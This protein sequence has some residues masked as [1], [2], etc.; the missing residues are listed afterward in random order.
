MTRELQGYK[1]WPVA[2]NVTELE[3]RFVWE[4]D[5]CPFAPGTLVYL[6]CVQLPQVAVAIGTDKAKAALG[7][8]L[9]Q[10]PFPH[11]GDWPLKVGCALYVKPAW[12][13]AAPELVPVSEPEPVDGVLSGVDLRRLNP[14]RV[15]VWLKSLAT[16]PEPFSAQPWVQD[17]RGLWARRP[18]L[19]APPPSITADSFGVDTRDAAAMVIQIVFDIP[20]TPTGNV[21]RSYGRFTAATAGP[22]SKQVVRFGAVEA[23]YYANRGA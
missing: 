7:E 17:N 5:A 6:Q 3:G 21:S 8:L 4:G 15:D 2:I 12:Q 23:P 19:M 14:G 11:D 18:D 22:L 1:I 13:F 20:G 10:G 9:Q 16:P